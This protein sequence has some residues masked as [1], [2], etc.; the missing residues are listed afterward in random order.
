MGLR[1]ALKHRDKTVVKSLLASSA[2]VGVLSFD[3]SP[4]RR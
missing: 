1:N 4:A 2:L 3:L